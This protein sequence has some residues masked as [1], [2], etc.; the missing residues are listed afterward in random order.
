[1]SEKAIVDRNNLFNSIQKSCLRGKLHEVRDFLANN[2]EFKNQLWLMQRCFD[3][4][5]HEY[6]P[7]KFEIAK[8]LKKE[9]DGIVVKEKH[10]M[11]AVG[12]MSEII[13]PSQLDDT[14]MEEEEGDVD[15][16]QVFRYLKKYHKEKFKLIEDL[17]VWSNKQ[18]GK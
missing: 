15:G 8:L 7:A 18:R 3:A 1:M 2:P 13:D 10:L 17:V 9:N 6:T 5:L 12:L 4:A 11:M 16:D 14:L